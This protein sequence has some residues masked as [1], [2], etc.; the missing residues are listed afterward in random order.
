MTY[1]QNVV[2]VAQISAQRKP[3][4]GVGFVRHDFSFQKSKFK[5]EC[6]NRLLRQILIYEVP[7]A[8]VADYGICPWK[9]LF[10]FIILDT[11]DDFNTVWKLYMRSA[12]VF[13]NYKD[14]L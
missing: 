11:S 5:P 13:Q 1:F 9:Y 8:G 7:A 2:S 10:I 3:H 12:A 4:N 6:V 14:I